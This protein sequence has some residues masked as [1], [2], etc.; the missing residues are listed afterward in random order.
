MQRQVGHRLV[1]LTSAEALTNYELA[2]DYRRTARPRNLAS[3]NASGSGICFLGNE[4]SASAEH[5]RLVYS[6]PPAVPQQP[7]PIITTAYPRAPVAPMAKAPRL[8]PHVFNPSANTRPTQL[9]GGN[10]LPY[11]GTM[12]IL[13]SGNLGSGYLDLASAMVDELDKQGIASDFI[14]DESFHMAR[15]AI[16]C[17]L[18]RSRRAASPCR[19][20]PA[21]LE[22]RS[23]FQSIREMHDGVQGSARYHRDKE[24]RFPGGRGVIIIA[25][26]SVF[27]EEA[28]HRVTELRI[29]LDEDQNSCIKQIVVDNGKWTMSP[30]ASLSDEADDTNRHALLNNGKIL[31]EGEH[32][33][34]WETRMQNGASMIIRC[35]DKPEP[36]IA[37]AAMN[38]LFAEMYRDGILL[39]EIHLDP[40]DVPRRAAILVAASEVGPSAVTTPPTTVSDVGSVAKAAAAG[41]V[42]CEG[43]GSTRARC[44]RGS[45]TH[46]CPGRRGSRGTSCCCTT[47]TRRSPY[48][49]GNT[50][51]SARRL[52]IT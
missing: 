35:A 40:P 38:M 23:F 7:A 41:G 2:A 22:T 45:A 44:S 32:A 12:L 36:P 46:C 31:L 25:G 28:L 11:S 50:V 37:V 13:V 26:R 34:H 29:W 5:V 3:L 8:E 30:Y 9:Y 43:S 33:M 16:E 18:C 14:D 52:G 1:L 51:D 39:R 42:S 47:A 15:P 20:C 24:H 19:S 6:S 48:P 10:V 21:S 49:S 17:E 27:Y 4:A